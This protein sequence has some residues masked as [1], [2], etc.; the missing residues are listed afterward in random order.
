M[1]AAPKTI[2]IYLPQGSAAGI[3]V[4]ELT[5]R[6]VQAVAVPRTGLESFF[7]RPESKHIGTYF[8]FGGDD[9]STKPIV[10]VGQTEDLRLRLKSHDANKEF[11]NTAVVLISRTHTF[12]QAHIRW[13]EWRALSA[14]A[15]AKRY[16]LDNGNAGGEPFVTEPIRADLEEIFE[17]GALLLE[18]L[19]YPV[20]R[21][22]LNFGTSTD[23]AGESELW[24]LHGPEAEARG[25][26]TDAGFVVL[27]GS[28]SRAKFSKAAAS[29][30]FAQT[31]DR[32]V[33]EGLLKPQGASMVFQEDIAF[34]SPSGAAAIVLARHANGWLSWRNAK[35]E[36]LDTIKRNSP[37]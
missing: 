15:E 4:A 6:I 8:L 24:F 12:T 28:K 14:T 26:F 20:F 16:T 27:K 2:Q 32:F 21:P 25:L 19:G 31:R 37:G 34:R 13:L 36:T 11:W 23:L 3:R 18:S 29:T 9:Q 35:G 22:Y 7:Q 5:T 1:N 10:Y 33:A 17:T 30:G